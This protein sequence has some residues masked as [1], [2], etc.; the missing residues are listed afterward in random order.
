MALPG[1]GVEHGR[2]KFYVA[3]ESRDWKKETK[4]IDEGD[5]R[6]RDDDADAPAQGG[7]AAIDGGLKAAAGRSF[8]RGVHSMGDNPAPAITIPADGWT[9]V[10]FSVRA[11][12]FADFDTTYDLRL[13]DDG[14]AI[15]PSVVAS[16]A[17][18]SNPDAGT[19]GSA[20]QSGGANGAARAG[21]RDV[22]ARPG[23]P[24]RP[25]D[26]DAGG[27]GAGRRRAGGPRSSRRTA[28]CR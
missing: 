24:A 23:D 2:A 10:E 21:R 16:M 20:D 14:S 8:S 19:V 15:Q 27:R 12:V 17:I 5:T 4:E 7:R 11:T 3:T 22:P 26:G 13:T 28:T 25:C 9:E 18:E 1:S 6:T